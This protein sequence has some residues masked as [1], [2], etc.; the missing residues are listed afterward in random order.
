[1]YIVL[2]FPKSHVKYLTIEAA[3]IL[4]INK[5]LEKVKPLK[6]QVHKSIHIETNKESCEKQVL[7]NS[8]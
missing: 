1:M 5:S 8:L 2:F 4:W 7:Q 3:V 6:Y